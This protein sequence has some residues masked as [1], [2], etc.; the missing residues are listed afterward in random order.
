MLRRGLTLLLLVAPLVVAC[1]RGPTKSTR[2]PAKAAATTTEPAAAPVSAMQ[3]EGKQYGAGVT[4]AATTS[5]DTLLADP[6]AFNGKTV[7]VEGMVTDVCPRRGCWFEMAGG[8]PGHKLKFKVTDGDM[9]FPVDAKGQLAVAQGEV[10]VH[11]L[12]LEQS[13]EYAEEQAK[14]YGTKYDPA[15]ITKPTQLVMLSGTGAVFRTKI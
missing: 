5:I 1:D 2:G 13:K 11:E 7:R 9:V 10:S 8:E 6:T 4:L 15:S 3:L 14:E 12:T